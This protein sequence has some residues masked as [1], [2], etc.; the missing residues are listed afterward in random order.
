[1]VWQIDKTK[2]PTIQEKVHLM[3]NEDAEKLYMLQTWVLQS[4]LRKS[5]KKDNA[6]D[7][8]ETPVYNF[9]EE[10]HIHLV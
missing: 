10:I 6:D 8:D 3:C 9:D 1:M 4:G 2:S 5:R 7:P